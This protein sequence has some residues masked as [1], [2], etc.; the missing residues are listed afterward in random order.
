VDFFLLQL[1]LE[2][3]DLDFGFCLALGANDYLPEPG[4]PQKNY[5]IKKSNLFLVE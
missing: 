3:E 4:D 2:D 5:Q 1:F